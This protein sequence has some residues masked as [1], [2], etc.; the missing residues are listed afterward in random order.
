MKL[1][2]HIKMK[3]LRMRHPQSRPRGRQAV[4]PP[5]TILVPTDF[6]YAADHAL[7]HA[8]LLAR[9]VRGAVT[10]LHVAAPVPDPDRLFTSI[11]T[12]QP[13]MMEL[14]R[15]RLTRL[16]R[17]MAVRP[18]E[19]EVR[20]GSA[21]EEIL[22]YADEIQADLIVIGS[23]GHSLLE[24]MLIGGTTEKVVRHCRRPVL[25]VPP[26]DVKLTAIPASKRNHPP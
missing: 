1:S 25:V 24:R 20:A 22:Q 4:W 16:A 23:H 21:A 18:R 13:Q 2:P 11:R 26:P 12:D 19:K 15:Q 10:L 9:R 17:R 14:S 5:A 3:R 8:A 7:K 6:S